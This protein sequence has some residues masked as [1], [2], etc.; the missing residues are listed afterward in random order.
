MAQTKNHARSKTAH[1]SLTKRAWVSFFNFFGHPVPAQQ[2][3]GGFR[4]VLFLYLII[5]FLTISVR[6][7]ISTSTGRIVKRFSPV[8]LWL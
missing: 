5:S 3:T 6:L 8:Q 4:H 2:A 1:L 7:I